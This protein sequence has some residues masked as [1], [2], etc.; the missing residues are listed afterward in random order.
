VR[1]PGRTAVAAGVVVA[2]AAGGTTWA[3]WP[4]GSSPAGS[5]KHASGPRPLTA[6]EA[7]RLAIVRFQNYRSGGVHFHTAISLQGRPVTLDGLVDYRNHVGYAAATG[8]GSGFSLQWNATTLLAWPA[9]AGQ[10]SP[11]TR[12]PAGPPAQRALAP[13][14]TVTDAVLLLVLQLGQDR[15]DNPQ[16]MQQGGAQWLRSATW[17]GRRVDVLSG[18]HAA[19][20]TST[21]PAVD[22]WLAGD[23]LVRVD[24]HPGGS[25]AAVPI[26]LDPAGYHPFPRS[27]ALR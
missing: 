22:Y 3:L 12:L 23:A 17:R 8:A 19:G 4:D 6:A 2:L 26:E 14:S 27:P 1:R 15:P 9:A 21:A 25:G 24:A 20:S 16:L 10:T 13:R 7:D 5:S 11:P 18:P